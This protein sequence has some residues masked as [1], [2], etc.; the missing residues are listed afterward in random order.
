MVG[1]QTG[2]GDESIAGRH[3]GGAEPRTWG[4]RKGGPRPRQ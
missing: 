3:V 2:R 1:E 4:A